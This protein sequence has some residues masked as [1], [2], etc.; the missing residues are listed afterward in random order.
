MDPVFEVELFGVMLPDTV[1]S[2]LALTIVLGVLAAIGRARL[3]VEGVSAFQTT[4]EAY[5]GWIEDTVRDVIDDEP[6]AYVPLIGTLILFI[7]ASNL[8]GVV[9]VIRPPTADLSTPAALALIVFFAVPYFGIR[10]QGLWGFLRTYAEPHPLLLPLNLLGELTRTLALAVRLFGNVMSGQMIVAI[11]IVVAGAIVPVPLMAL[12]LLTALVQA[13]IFGVL[14]A[15]YIGA[16]VRVDAESAPQ[17]DDERDPPPP[18]DLP[19]PP[20]G[21]HP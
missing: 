12:G 4:I 1:F 6:D 19:S 3:S 10:R 17:H 20:Q 8:L 15:V 13:Y 9:P 16:A 11:L 5:H 21:A 7:A 2:T 14:A 18:S